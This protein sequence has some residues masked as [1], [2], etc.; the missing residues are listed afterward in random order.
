MSSKWNLIWLKCVQ[1]GSFPTWYCGMYRFSKTSGLSIWQVWVCMY[2]INIKMSLPNMAKNDILA[3]PL[4]MFVWRSLLRSVH[5]VQGGL[6]CT[7]HTWAVSGSYSTS[8]KW[9]SCYQIDPLT[10]NAKLSFDEKTRKN[11]VEKV[12]SGISD[13]AGKLGKEFYIHIYQIAPR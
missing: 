4:V 5:R 7:L 2:R 10:K 11:Y 9:K 12:Y 3:T 8:T 13:A 6:G 1:N